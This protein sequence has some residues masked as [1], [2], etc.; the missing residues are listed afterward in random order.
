MAVYMDK[1]DELMN[2]PDACNLARRGVLAGLLTAGAV[3]ARV[4]GPH[5]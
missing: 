5:Q 1:L 4:R 2:A 3:S